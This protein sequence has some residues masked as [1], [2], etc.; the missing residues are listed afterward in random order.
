M[1]AALARVIYDADL[2]VL[3]YNNSPPIFSR[4]LNSVGREWTYARFMFN[5]LCV[6]S[7]L[8]SKEGFPPPENWYRDARECYY[9]L[10]ELKDI[11]AAAFLSW[12]L[13]YEGPDATYE[14]EKCVVKYRA[15]SYAL[16]DVLKALKSV[17]KARDSLLSAAHGLVAERCAR[18]KEHP[19]S[20]QAALY[21]RARFIA[22][23]EDESGAACRC[24]M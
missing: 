22:Y 13:D 2:L 17:A 5:H 3:H 6:A 7:G 24:R 1:R 19:G 9:R 16:A 8:A 4:A 20:S 21:P 11:E 10:G 12:A 18:E 15:F 14:T 23:D